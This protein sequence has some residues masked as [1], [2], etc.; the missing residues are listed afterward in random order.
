MRV[1]IIGANGQLGSDLVKALR[2]EEL[3]SLTHAD[4]KITDF[5]QVTQV[6]EKHHP[7]V[8]INT[9][10]YQGVDE[11][12]GNAIKSLEVNAL[13]VCN[14]ALVC[15]KQRA[16][17][18]HMSTDYVFDGTKGTP[19]LETDVPNPINIYGISKLAGEHFIRHLLD[20][21]FIV[22]TS[23]LYGLAGSNGGNFVELMLQQAR[24]GREI[25]VVDDQVLTPTYTVDLA[26]KIR[27]LLATS[28]FGLYHI[29]NSGACSWYG[30]ARKIFEL[31]G[32]EANLQRTTTEAFGAKARHPRYSVLGHNALIEAGLNDLRPWEKALCA[33]LAQR[34]TVRD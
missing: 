22:R 20:Q 9:A 6:L 24:K 15:Q 30:F 14:L 19:Y 13:G 34:A 33:Y 3:I 23:G 12:E 28:R 16:V 27:D 10:A 29:T 32:V 31:A 1:A 4:I 25:H 26:E 7:E 5:N 18:L 8:I 21:Y 11:C 2:C 17:L